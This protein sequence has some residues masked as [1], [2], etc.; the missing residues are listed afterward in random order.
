M[1]DKYCTMQY[2]ATLKYHNA[3]AEKISAG[4]RYQFQKHT[5]QTKLENFNKDLTETENMKL[6][7][8]FRAWDCGQL[9]FTFTKNSAILKK[10]E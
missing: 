8:Y 6:N 5:L 4:T 9:V 10:Y 2:V 7:G 3:S 1:H